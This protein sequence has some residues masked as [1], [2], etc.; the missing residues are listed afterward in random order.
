M[1][2]GY[3][4]GN[5]CCDSRTDH[6]AGVAGQKKA[7]ICAVFGQNSR[8]FLANCGRTTP[9]LRPNS[10]WA[11]DESRCSGKAPPSSRHKSKPHS[12]E[13]PSESLGVSQ[14]SRVTAR[15]RCAKASK[16]A[17]KVG[18]TSKH[19]GSRTVTGRLTSRRRVTRGAKNGSR[20]D[21][22]AAA[23]VTL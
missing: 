5:N 7:R 9:I 21:S 14:L 6:V 8:L 1:L 23:V 15:A 12:V 4:A 13:C 11:S 18:S 3:Q 17:W 16:R 10:Y 2:L 19:R 22:L 20:Q